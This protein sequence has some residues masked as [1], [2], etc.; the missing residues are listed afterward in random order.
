MLLYWCTAVTGLL[1]VFAFGAI[2]G[3][4]INVVVYRLPR[5]LNIVSP[6]SACPAC[7]T[8]LSW[9]EN[10]PIFGWLALRG[11]CRFCRTRISPEYPLVELLVALPFVGVFTLW[12]MRPSLLE[13]LGVN[14][15]WF[16]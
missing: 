15:Q 14:V 3:S 7:G 8:T 6:P 5:G 10:F 11:K 12:F 9:R 16:T 4:F 13:L 1:F 2:C